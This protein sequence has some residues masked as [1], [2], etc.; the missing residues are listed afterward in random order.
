MS[1]QASNPV[2]LEEVWAAKQKGQRPLDH[3]HQVHGMSNSAAVQWLGERLGLPTWNS[4]HFDHCRLADEAI[5]LSKAQQVGVAAVYLLQAPDQLI[6]VTDDPFEQD[7]LTQL[8]AQHGRYVQLALADPTVIRTWLIHQESKHT[9]FAQTLTDNAPVLTSANSPMSGLSATQVTYAGPSEDVGQAVN[10]LNRTLYEALRLGASDVHLESVSQGLCVRYR[11]DGMLDTITTLQGQAIKEQLISRIK[12]LASLN[13]GETR[14]PQD[15]GFPVTYAN[16]EVDL[17]VS[18]MP[19]IHGEDAVIR[20]LDKQSLLAEHQQLSLDLLGFDKASASTMRRLLTAPHGML[21]VAGP[22]GS[23]KTTTLYAA[24]VETHTGR[25][26]VITIE[27]PVEYHLPGV[28]QI[29]VNEKKGLTFAKGLRSILRHD[30]DRIMVGEIRDKETAEIAVQA[31]L[32]GHQVLTTVH[33]NNVYDVFSRFTHMGVD[34]YALASAL[35]GVWA[36]RLI[37]QIC[38]HC[39]QQRAPEADTLLALGDTPNISEI[40]FYQGAGCLHCRGTG[41]KGRLAV[42]E[43]LTLNDDI[44]EMIANRRS[45]RDI[46]GMATRQGALGLRARALQLAREGVTTLEEVARVTYE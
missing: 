30:P 41:Y 36:Q 38:H 13:I 23:G 28:L 14:L 44:R 32:T 5:S 37:R 26:K 6:L 40:P 11:V 31:A 17:R 3:L 4:A 7:K 15:G 8:E 12:V 34:S 27:D 25:E 45:I 19:S 42:C 1:I 2:T 29:P 21:L 33:A 18:I 9:P 22:T 46:K 43:L 39:K 24:L 35:N 20:I 16:R 10:V